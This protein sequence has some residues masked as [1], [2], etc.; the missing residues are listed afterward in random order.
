MSLTTKD[1]MRILN[2]KNGVSTAF[3]LSQDNP[4]EVKE[5][6]PTG[7]RWLDSI[8][9]KGKIAGIPVGKI[10]EIAGL[11][12]SGKSFMAGQIAANAQK[13]DFTVVYFDSESALDPD[14]LVRAGVDLERFV[15]VQAVSIEQVLEQT[16]A[17]LS[18]G[19]RL[20]FIWDSLANTVSS[21]EAEVNFDPS[22][23]MAFNA[24]VL[25]LGMKKLT[26]PI[27]NKNS[28]FLV[29]NQL[30]T[31]IS[32][33]PYEMLANP[34]TTPG[35]KAVIYAYSLRIWLTGRKNK[36][37]LIYDDNG[38]IMGSAVKVKLKKSRFGTEG[39]TCE[40]KIIWGD[41]DTVGIQDE[42]S[43]FE[44]LKATESLT[45]QSQGWYTLK[46][47]DRRF[48]ST[49]WVEEL[50]NPDFRKCVLDAMDVEIVSKFD[51]RTGDASVFY[52]NDDDDDDMENDD[53]VES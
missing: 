52:G 18:K 39:R 12:A 17:L 34:Y 29:L 26:I 28:V 40:F 16:E 9:C 14:F 49:N 48:R 5:W 41:P 47:W 33:N 11:E 37:N 10:V 51:N 24:R 38:F 7:S 46:G 8:I 23:L 22:K 30:K 36:D 45:H 53:S 13:K 43:W 6:I 27:A 50:K 3:S 1:M 20:F 4:T 32:T 42:A 31:N 35:G 19:E 15:Y 25:S 21:K 2:K 44:A